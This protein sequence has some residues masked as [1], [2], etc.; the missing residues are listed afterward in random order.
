MQF[1]DVTCPH[2]GLLCDDLSIEVN[3]LALRVLNTDCQKCTG[4]FADASI[5]GAIPSPSIEGQTTSINDALEKAASILR[6]AH[7]PLVYGLSTDVQGS[8]EAVAL[9]EKIGGVIDH[10]NGDGIRCNGSVIQRIGKV[11]TTLSEVK[12][13]ADFVIIFGNSLLNNFPRF[14][15]RMLMPEKTL[16]LEGSANKKIIILDVSASVQR[17]KHEVHDNIECI[18]LAADSLESM[19]HS[20]QNIVMNDHVTTEIDESIKILQE[21]K[22]QI[23]NSHYTTLV[24]YGGDFQANSAEY[25]I[26]SITQI[27][28]EFTKEVRCVGLP[29]GGS[30]GEVTANAVATWQTG[31]PLPVAFMGDAP[32][33]DPVLFNGKTML[34]NGDVDCMLWIGTYH[35]QDVPPTL[36]LPTIVIGH[37][38]MHCAQTPDV[39]IPVGVPG[40]DHRGLACRTDS[41]ATLPL[42]AIRT[43]GLPSA[44][45]ILRQITQLI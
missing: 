36:K 35:S 2:C 29:L 45:D 6:S 15:E 30:K 26:Q 28:K 38:N 43:S 32:T 41:V 37:P 42:H 34:A 12:N 10:V 27:I 44:S 22:Q 13:R 24:W 40:I 9:T 39:F 8:R 4:A 1:D 23:L 33:H 20:F 25:T 11:K 7:Q 19:I 18:T 3:Q 17:I 5:Q 14:T 21:L 16:G 31:S